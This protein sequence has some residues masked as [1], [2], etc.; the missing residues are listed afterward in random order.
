MIVE[1]K[2]FK[3]IKRIW[4]DNHN[5]FI[6]KESNELLINSDDILKI[7]YLENNVPAGYV[8]VYTKDDFCKLETFPDKTEKNGNISYIWEIVT[9]KKYMG[10]GIASKL[11]QY[12]LEKFKGYRIYSCIAKENIPSLKLHEKYGFKEAY[13]FTQDKEQIMLVKSN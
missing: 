4:K 8:A 6:T 2:Y 11:M 12:V 5:G 9:D 3:D 13:Q 10:K 7:V 1:N